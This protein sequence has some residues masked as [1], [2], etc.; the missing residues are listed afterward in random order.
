MVT[1]SKSPYAVGD[2][3]VVSMPADSWSG[4]SES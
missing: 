2:L 1:R 3:G 4:H